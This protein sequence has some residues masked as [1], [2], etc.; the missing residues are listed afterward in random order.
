MI[1]VLGSDPPSRRPG[2]H[3]D[4]VD[5][6]GLRHTSAECRGTWRSIVGPAL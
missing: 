6:P 1:D 4:F 2:S 3:R 5:R